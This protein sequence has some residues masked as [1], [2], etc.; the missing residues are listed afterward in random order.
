MEILEHDLNQ[1]RIIIKYTRT[2]RIGDS[3]KY[4]SVIL[5]IVHTQ[6]GNSTLLELW[7]LSMTQL[8]FQ[9]LGYMHENLDPNFSS[10]T[11]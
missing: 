9:K 11:S 8:E 3:F 6:D 1:T 2:P 7:D 5:G 4:Q 10:I